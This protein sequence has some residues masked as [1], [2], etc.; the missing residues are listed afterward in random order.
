MEI[1]LTTHLFI[2]VIPSVIAV[3]SIIYYFVSQRHER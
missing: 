1:P 3:V 2:I